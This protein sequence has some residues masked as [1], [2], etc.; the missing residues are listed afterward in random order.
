MM[1]ANTEM[2]A[3]RGMADSTEEAGD[4]EAGATLGS[5]HRP[6][7]ED[8]AEDT[9]TRTKQLQTR[10]IP[11][12]FFSFNFCLIDFFFSIHVSCFKITIEKLC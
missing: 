8:A 5:G 12:H 4:T 2:M 1:A 10:Y 11:V 6:T 3:S 9:D 7:L